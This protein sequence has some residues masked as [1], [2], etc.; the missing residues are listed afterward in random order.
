MNIV[1]LSLE[2]KPGMRGVS[3]TPAYTLEKDG[4][5]AA[6]W[7]LYSHTGTHADAPIHFGASNETIDK[8]PLSNFMGKAWVA[9]I[10]DVEPRQLL[11]SNDLGSVAETFE[12]GDCL[13]LRTDWHKHADDLAIYRD[14]LPRIGDELANW[15]VARRI[16]L[17][18]VEPPSIADVNTLEEIDRIHKILLGAGITIVEGLCNLDQ[19]EPQVSFMTL[20][21]NLSAG[22]GAASGGRGGLLGG[23]STQPQQWLV[24]VWFRP[25]LESPRQN[26]I[27]DRGEGAVPENLGAG[28]RGTEQFKVLGAS[29]P[30][31]EIIPTDHFRDQ[32]IVIGTTEA[33]G[34][35]SFST[36]AFERSIVRQKIPI[37]FCRFR[38]LLDMI[39]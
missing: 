26:S 22:D 5:N 21:L 28:R 36:S 29:S 3:V 4:W 39:Q 18:G 24:V 35:A 9:N 16:K 23:S 27:G 20:P 15:C 17:L 19:L 33:L 31:I 30:E 32:T 1:D 2:L 7:N 25:S 10:P 11:T 34:E 38:D 14:G 6:N 8:M 37:S 13:L 12:D